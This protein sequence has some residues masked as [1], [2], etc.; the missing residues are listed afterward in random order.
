MYLPAHFAEHDQAE[1]R[2]LI[3]QH[4]LG[5]LVTLGSEG[6]S[7]NHLPFIFDAGSGT[8]GVL[9]GH[10]ARGNQVWQDFSGE[11]EAMV[12]FQGPSAYVAPTGIQRRRR[13]TATR[14]PTTTR[15]CMPTVAW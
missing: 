7:A 1:L 14:R 8:Q 15:W 6:L 9:L 2:R 10:V 4:P 3:T 13:R 11:H 12:I 5:T